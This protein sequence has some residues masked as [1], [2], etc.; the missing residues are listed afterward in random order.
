MAL[1]LA[2]AVFVGACAGVARPEA[3]SLAS[4]P[5]VSESSTTSAV[6]TPVT[7]EASTTTTVESF[8]TSRVVES[9]EPSPSPTT[10]LAGAGL[11]STTA[12][13]TESFDIEEVREALDALGAMF[14]ALDGAIGSVEFDEGEAP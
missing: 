7:S 14:E 4:E 1:A 8:S 11:T 9:A 3:R 10:T 6:T 2:A 5:T 13:P 12:N